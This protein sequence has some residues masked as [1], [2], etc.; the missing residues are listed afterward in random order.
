MARLAASLR[1]PPGCARHR[2]VTLRRHAHHRAVILRALPTL[3]FASAA[4]GALP[5]DLHLATELDAGSGIAEPMMVT[6]AGDGSGRLFVAGRAGEVW[7]RPRGA[8]QV[9]SPPFLDLAALVSTAGEGGLL[10]LAFHPDYAQNGHVFVSYTDLANDSVIA[11]YTVSSADPQ[12]VDAAS[13][14]VL[15]RIDQGSFIHKAGDLHFGADGYLYAT[16]GDGAEGFG[17]DDCGRA[18]SLSAQDVLANDSD[19]DCTPDAGFTG[20]PASRALMGKLLRIDVDSGSPAGSA[21][22]GGAP[23]GSAAYAIPADNVF[24]QGLPG[25]CGE[26]HAW[27]L[28]NPFRFA[29]DA[30]TGDIF[31]GDVGESETEEIDRLPAGAGGVDFG[32]PRCEGLLGDCAGSAPPLFADDRSGGSCAIT[33]GRVYRGRIGALRGRYAFSDYCT[34]RIRFAWHEAGSWRFEPWLDGGFGQHTCFGE[35]EAGELYVCEVAAGKIKR[36]ADATL[37]L[38]GFEP[39]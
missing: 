17:I 32:W 39:P 36:I 28:R 1:Q 31:L 3:L 9:L 6:H 23:D 24:A 11:R 27:G 19:P 37:F 26:I 10:G 15:L 14:R 16:F 35:D 13:A 33:G 21:T 38:D 7:I 5:G 4:S 29:I 12:R 30:A 18:Q 25:R 22:C 8:T 34:G 20:N 2:T